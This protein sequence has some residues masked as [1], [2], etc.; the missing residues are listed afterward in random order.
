MALLSEMKVLPF[1]IPKAANHAILFQEDRG[2]AFYDR[3]HEHAEIQISLVLS[4]EGDLIVGDSVGRFQKGDVFVLGSHIP[5]LFQSDSACTDEAH[6]LSIFFTRDSFGSTFFD[7]NEMRELEQ[8]FERIT[9]GIRLESHLDA[10][11]SLFL[12]ISKA[13]PFERLVLFLQLLHQICC[14]ET[15][16]LA[17]FVSSKRYSENEGTRMNNV[18][19]HTVQNYQREITLKE[20]AE[21]AHLTP[22]AFCRYFKQRT[23]KTYFQFLM[24]IRCE[25][26]CRLLLNTPDLSI[27]GI[28]ELVGFRN[29][30]NFNRKF[31]AHKSLTPSE[32]RTKKKPA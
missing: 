22:T 1:K 8:F 7:M 5:H 9:T 24:K 29:I 31:K 32:Y 3:F 18:L 19:Q 14:A 4:G 27:A 17:S 30:S 20:I 25:H 21:I 13:A 6:M 11:R 2:R 16:S 15:R 23:N 10:V 26:A 12:E 28:A